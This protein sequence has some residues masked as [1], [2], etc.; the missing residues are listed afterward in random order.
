MWGVSLYVSLHTNG[1]CM[2]NKPIVIDFC[3]FF[4]TYPYTH[5]L[6]DTRKYTYI[7][8]YSLT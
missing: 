6:T 8:I 5:A 1:Y 4:P 7:Y 3:L 2:Q